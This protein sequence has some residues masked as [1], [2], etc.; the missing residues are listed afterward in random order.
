[1]KKIT[2]LI[3]LFVSKS[4]YSQNDNDVQIKASYPGGEVA[5][6]KYLTDEFVIPERCMG[7]GINL[8]VRM[9]FEV[10]TAGII[11]GT[12]VLE[13]TKSCPEFT[14]EAIRVLKKSPRWVP[15]QNN[16]HLLK[17]FREIPFKWSTT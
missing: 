14:T 17:S 12:T 13:E 8:Y 2:F 7:L 3:I 9:R 6:L 15:G 4:L 5:F 10:D 16:G 1:M 11:S